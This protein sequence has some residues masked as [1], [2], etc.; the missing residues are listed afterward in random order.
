MASVVA[1]VVLW[2]KLTLAQSQGGIILSSATIHD[3]QTIAATLRNK[4]GTSPNSRKRKCWRVICGRTA[5]PLCGKR[6]A[7][8]PARA[9]L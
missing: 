5:L 2:S 8:W 4:T 9:K 6:C 3:A 7:Q 1:A